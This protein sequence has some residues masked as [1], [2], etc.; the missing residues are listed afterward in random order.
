MRGLVLSLFVHAGMLAAGLIYLP[1]AA[2]LLDA[3]PVVPIEMVTIAETTNIRAAAPEP[4]P[5]P[6]ETPEETI[7][8]E[9]EAPAPAPEPEPEPV[10][11]EP[12]IIDIAPTEEPEPEP[13]PVEPEPEPEPEPEQPERQQTVQPEAPE[14]TEPSLFDMLGNIERDVAEARQSQGSPEEGETRDAVG[15]ASA[16]TAT[17]RDLINSHIVRQRCWRMP[18]DAPYPEERVVTI[19][20]RLNRDGTLDGPPELDERRTRDR[21]DSFRDVIRER[22]LR[23][24]VE[25]APYPLPANQYNQWRLIRVNFGPDNASQQ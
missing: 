6:E 15:N 11:T 17:L 25:C 5:E 8:D 3:T 20:M 22:A 13:E 14:E 18:L 10:E 9:I 23:A 1:R 21:N 7:E 12:E 24:A 16:M 19:T 2:Q 4:E